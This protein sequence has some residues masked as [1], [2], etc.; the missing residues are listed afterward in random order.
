MEMLILVTGYSGGKAKFSN[1]YS[2]GKAN[3]K[4]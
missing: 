1:S 2:G 4:I 3:C